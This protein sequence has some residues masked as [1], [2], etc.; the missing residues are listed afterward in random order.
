MIERSVSSPKEDD[1]K[2]TKI[3]LWCAWGVTG[4]TQPGVGKN[5]V[6]GVGEGQERF[7]SVLE[8]PPHLKGACVWKF[9]A[10]MSEQPTLHMNRN[11]L[12]GVDDRRLPHPDSPSSVTFVCFLPHSAEDG[13]YSL[14]LRG[15]FWSHSL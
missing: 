1:K 5:R 3:V 2:K 14:F 8:R 9:P 7:Q 10:V 6:Y 12:H 11:V 13:G 15:S 4:H